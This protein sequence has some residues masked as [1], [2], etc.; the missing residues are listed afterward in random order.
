ME[1]DF[2][3]IADAAE[4]VNGKLYML[5]GGWTRF[6]APAFPAPVRLAICLGLLVDSYELDRLR[7]VTF[8]LQRDT[9]K[10]IPDIRVDVRMSAAANATPVRQRISVV[11]NTAFALP[12]PGIY[13]L[14]ATV[15]GLSEFVEFEAV[16]ILQQ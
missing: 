10:V 3:Q 6:N 1:I 7:S 8:S 2:L 9:T 11:T 13:H 12:G 14:T 15:D 4:A 16:Q 5:G